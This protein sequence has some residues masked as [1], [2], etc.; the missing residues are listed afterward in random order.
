[1]R[2][3]R[4]GRTGI[5]VS[6]LCFGTMSFGGDADEAESGKL[7]IAAREAGI[8]FF[9]CAN[10]YAKGASER[11][12]GMLMAKERDQ[13]VITS[14][15]ANPTTDDV[16]DRGTNRRHMKMAVED[17][18]RRLKTD[19]LDIL[20]LHRWDANTP[21]E[22]TLRGLEDLV[23][24]GKVIYTGA[25]NF[26]AW[27]V[28]KGLGISAREQWTRFEVIQ[29]MYSLVKRQVEVEILPMAASES[30]GVMTYGP[31]GGGL[32]SGK[33][34]PDKRPASGRLIDN[35]EYNARYDEAWAYETAGKF[36]EF[37]AGRG[38]HPVTL[39]VAWAKTNPTVTCPIIGARSVEQLRPSLDAINFEMDADLRD[40][41]S[42]LSRAPVPATDR[43]EEQR[44]STAGRRST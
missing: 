34:G 36:T 42:A 12:L 6:E 21:L 32:L 9:D 30:L 1:M 39:A 29:P 26:A 17:S 16:N 25:S 41:L 10:R 33:Y 3:K 35:P 40:E 31:V 24:E 20:I 27:Q 7:Y 43:L 15:C 44:A 8:N 19:R 37:A 2:Y 5:A 4:L 38:V 11:I 22:E 28:M 14:K 18:L 13:V 23:R